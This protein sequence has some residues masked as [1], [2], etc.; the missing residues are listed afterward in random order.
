M[1]LLDFDQAGLRVES[2][3]ENW[4]YGLLRGHH[5]DIGCHSGDHC[6]DVRHTCVLRVWRDEQVLFASDLIVVNVRPIKHHKLVIAAHDY[7]LRNLFKSVQM[8][9]RVNDLGCFVPSRTIKRLGQVSIQVVLKRERETTIG[10]PLAM[11]IIDNRRDNWNYWGDS[12][13]FDTCGTLGGTDV[14]SSPSSFGSTADD[15]AINLSVLVDL[16]ELLDCLHALECAFGHWQV[17]ELFWVEAWVADEVVPG[18][19]QETVFASVPS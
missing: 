18:P 7:V 3:V 4:P 1:E 8:I 14:P 17:D 2:R 15:P 19:R 6:H 11:D 10:L 16:K 5:T 13:Y 12:E 9:D